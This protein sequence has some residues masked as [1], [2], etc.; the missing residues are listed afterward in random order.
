M[1]ELP[2]QR[3]NSPARK[4]NCVTGEDTGQEGI[5]CQKAQIHR[6]IAEAAVVVEG[7]PSLVGL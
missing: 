5:M 7:R 3:L 1:R 6:N 4:V 2:P